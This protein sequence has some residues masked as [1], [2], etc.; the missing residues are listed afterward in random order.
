MVLAISKGGG[1]SYLVRPSSPLFPTSPCQCET[2]PCDFAA[3]PSVNLASV[4]LALR[5]GDTLSLAAGNYAGSGNCG[6]KITTNSADDRPITVRGAEGA[7]LST[8]IDCESA[9]PVVEGM[10]LGAHLHLERIHFTRAY[11]S[12]GGGGVLS[13]DRGSRIMIENCRISKTTSDGEG[14]ALLVR[15]SSLLVYSSHFEENSAAEKGGALA[16]VD[17]SVAT[18][19]DNIVTHCF[20]PHGGT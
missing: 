12:G 7:S 16:I 11:R 20:A 15:N 9:G 17:Q 5:P 4:V 2:D 13:A 14:G 3:S 10:V 8:I 19:K 1:T 18:L 6:W